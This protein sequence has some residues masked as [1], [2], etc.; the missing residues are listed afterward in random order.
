MHR[1]L[2]ASACRPVD[3]SDVKLKEREQFLLREA[4]RALVVKLDECAL[5]A[6]EEL[7]ERSRAAVGVAPVRLVDEIL[8]FHVMRCFRC[9]GRFFSV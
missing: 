7:G 1:Q 5:E 3:M 2:A 9:D 6:F 4:W 8:F